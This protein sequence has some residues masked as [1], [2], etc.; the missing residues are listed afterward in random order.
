MH[1]VAILNT[2]ILTADGTYVMCTIGIDEARELVGNGNFISAVGHEATA[3]VLT[4]LFGVKI[5]VNRIMFEQQPGQKAVVFKLNGRLP[6]GKVLS[7]EDIE[8]IGYSLKLLERI[9]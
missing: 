8:S 1:P 2:S 5:P 9:A 3:Q 4:T 7:V 6:E